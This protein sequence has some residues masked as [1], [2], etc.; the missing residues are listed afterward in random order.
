MW[1]F[2]LFGSPNSPP[3]SNENGDYGFK[4][5]PQTKLE[6]LRNLRENVN[7]G[8]EKERCEFPRQ[9]DSLACNWYNKVP[10]FRSFFQSEEI[11]WLLIKDVESKMSESVYEK[12]A[13]I[14]FL[15][16]TGYKDR[17]YVDKCGVPLLRRTTAVHLAAKKSS[18]LVYFLLK[19]YNRF[20]FNYTDESGLTHFHV[21]CM[22]GLDNE[23]EKILN[24]G[25][26]PNC[27]WPQT[28]DSPLHLALAAGHVEVTKLLLLGG[29]DPTLV[30]AEGSTPLHIVC[31]CRVNVPWND[32]KNVEL[33]NILFEISA[34]RYLT[35]QVDAR[36]KSGRTPLQWAVAR[37][38]LDLVN[39]LLDR[40]ADR[41]SFVFPAE[42]H[43]DECFKVYKNKQINELKFILAFGLLAVAER[44]E[45][46]GYRLKQ[47][48]ALTIIKLFI[49]HG[50]IKELDFG[51]RLWI[52]VC[53][54]ETKE[55]LIRPNLSLYD[56]VQLRFDEAEK[57]VSPKDGLEFV[58]TKYNPIDFCPLLC[59]AFLFETILRGFFRRWELEFF[60]TLTRY[61]LPILCCEMI[62][63]QLMTE[64]VL[65]MCLAT[66][67]IADEESQNIGYRLQSAG[68]RPGQ[69]GPNTAALGT[70]IR[71]QRLDR[72]TA[73]KR[74]NPNMA[75]GDGS[76][77]LHVI[78]KID[79][80]DVYRHDE[81]ENIVQLTE[82]FFK[83]NDE[84]HQ[85]VQVETLDKLGRTPLQWAVARRFPK[86]VDALLSHGA[87]LSN[88][89]FP[90]ESHFDE[91]LEA[92]GCGGYQSK[93]RLGSSVLALIEFLEK[94]GYE[95]ERSDALTIMKLFNK[96]GLFEKS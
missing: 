8:V 16:R 58:L 54:T 18:D 69:V 77:P 61:R 71:S 26:D 46:K 49:K 47:N 91:C 22:S 90:T 27:I 5:T 96:H 95:L 92:F 78:C 19:I 67:G 23:V 33:A 85:S 41:T 31:N 38:D 30:N 13:F 48:D 29:T 72:I 89:A 83:I 76:T 74:R 52:E 66:E 70:G 24:S 15:I 65:R 39:V 3:E 35:M 7:W 73:E 93:L 62:I 79:Y 28:G 37:L 44:L 42:R 53:A 4:K 17:P 25:Q 94:R 84:I 86:V 63:D 20:D 10:N 64:D 81:S 11:D 80:K 75:S 56:L 21:T 40:G 50:L 34:D 51:Y 45:N 36:D 82:L 60:L 1:L 88:F 32:K 55:L 59:T 12:R 6:R 43:F 68:R 87:D 2:R 9:F 57:L 14:A